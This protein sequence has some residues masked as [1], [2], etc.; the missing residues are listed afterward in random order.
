M[1]TVNKKK[2]EE[3]FPGKKSYVCANCN[4]EVEREVIKTKIQYWD[5]DLQKW[6]DEEKEITEIKYSCVDPYN[7]E[8]CIPTI[9]EI[10][11]VE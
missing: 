4:G 9:V 1:F 5:I 10:V 6:V 2:L 11:D 3:L 8:D 7:V